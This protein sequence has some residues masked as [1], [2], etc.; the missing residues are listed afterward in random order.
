M[1]SERHDRQDR[2]II[3]K[4]RLLAKD[5]D[6]EQKDRQY[7]RLRQYALDCQ[8]H[9]QKL[10]KQL[11]YRSIRFWMKTGSKISVYLAREILDLIRLMITRPRAVWARFHKIRHLGIRGMISKIFYAGTD[12][13]SLELVTELMYPPLDR[14]PKISVVMPVYNVE[15][16]WLVLAIESVLN[17]AYDNFELIIVDDGSTRPDI[18]QYLG[19]L[20]NTKISVRFNKKNNGISSASN[21]GVALAGG[22]FV[23]LL[24][25]DDLLRENALYEVAK[26]INDH[27]PDVIY[28]DE[29]RVDI[30]ENKKRP[31]LKPDWSPDLLR[32]QMYICHFLVFKKSL[33]DKAGGFESRFDGSQDYDLMLRFS[34]MTTNIHHIPK[35][36]YFWRE[37]GSSTAL[38]SDSKPASESAGLNA[39]DCHLKRVYGKDAHACKTGNRFVYDARYPLNGDVKASIIIPTRDQSALLSDCIY[40]ITDKTEYANFEVLIMDNNSKEERTQELFKTVTTQ[41]DNIRVIDAPYSFNWSRL[42]NHG[43]RHATGDILIFLNNDTLVISP[44]WL[45]RICENASRPEIGVVG[46]L[47]LYEDDTIQHAG[48]VVG[49]GGWADHVFKNCS[50]EHFFHPFVSPVVTRNV[51]AV[52]G[53]CLGIS[54]KVFDEVNGFDEEFIICG[55]D[56]AFALKALKKGYM[57][58]YNP[59]VKLYHLESKSRTSY[60][61]DVDFEMSRIAY[62]EMIQ[63]GDPYY[64]PN[65]CLESLTPVLKNKKM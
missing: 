20:D 29:A 65:L 59:Y 48:V 1:T 49:M 64:N 17:Q 7:T 34:E 42:N 18:R 3:L 40:S 6:I 50:P 39:L 52:T 61:P 47:L 54:R 10:E 43:A 58:L 2:L 56:V 38:N 55:S 4:Q 45:T 5:R 14:Y 62:A 33:F 22:E 25:N 53:A 51:S 15:K 28:S 46:G 13:L 36:L 41:Y 44:E 12:E 37:I 16:K 19:Q 57:N 31:F 30:H 24:D 32:S 23:A 11:Q 8:N 26:A 21:D 35:I 60:I 9:I 63:N 27:Y